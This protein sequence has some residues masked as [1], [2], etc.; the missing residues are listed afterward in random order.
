MNDGPNVSFNGTTN[1]SREEE[2]EGGDVITEGSTDDVEGSIY[3]KWGNMME[4]TNT[5]FDRNNAD[6]ASEESVLDANH[7]YPNKGN[8]FVETDD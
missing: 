1:H 2:E 6:A 7:V 5:V 3:D 4:E 8:L